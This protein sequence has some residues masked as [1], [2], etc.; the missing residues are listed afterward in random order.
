MIGIAATFY[1]LSVVYC[2]PAILKHS[3]LLIHTDLHSVFSIMGP[4]LTHVFTVRAFL[5]QDTTYTLGPQKGASG[6]HRFVATLTDGTLTSTPN[7]PNGPIEGRILGGADWLLLDTSSNTGSL[8]VRVQIKT[9][10]G[11]IIY[12]RHEGKIRMDEATEKALHWHPEAKT[13]KSQDHYWA[14]SP[15]FEASSE[16]LKWLEQSVFL[17]TA[18]WYIPG[19]GTQ[20]VEFEVWQLVS[21]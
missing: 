10:K 14:A 1:T 12:M 15:I 17:A 21:A 20:A 16:R 3:G 9:D 7:C 11:E 19:D 2:R 4:K 8:D 5:T 13:T 6:P 18:H